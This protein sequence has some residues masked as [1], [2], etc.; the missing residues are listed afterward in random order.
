M[1]ALVN[2]PHGRIQGVR[3]GTVMSV[4]LRMALGVLDVVSRALDAL[5]EVL[6]LVNRNKSLRP[7]FSIS[8]GWS[9]VPGME[10]LGQGTQTPGSFCLPHN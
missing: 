1:L 4:L 3:K 6:G 8:V 7:R 9:K 10:D 5:P 2:W